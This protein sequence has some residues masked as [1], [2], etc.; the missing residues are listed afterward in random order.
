MSIKQILY[1]NK[2]DK[3]ILNIIT[4]TN[5]VQE[6]KE[7]IAKTKW[8]KLTYVGRQ[9]NC[10]TQFFKNSNLKASFKTDNRIGKLLSKN[11]NINKNKFNKRGV[12]QLT[13]RDCNRK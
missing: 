4:I 6:Q 1:N 2:Y 9:T 5:D 10:I 12:Y 3:R 11:K 13:Y 8:A 7:V